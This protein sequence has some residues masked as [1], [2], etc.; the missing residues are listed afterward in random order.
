M[1]NK[2]TKSDLIESVVQISNKTEE[3]VSEVIDNFLNALKEELKSGS[4]IEIRG[5]GSFELKLRK[6]RDSAR[7]PKTGEIVSVPPRYAV[8]FK[9]G[10]ELKKSVKELKVE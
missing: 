9:A 1:N 7:N 10:Q 5:F 4:K 3:I 2:V 6:G 8:C